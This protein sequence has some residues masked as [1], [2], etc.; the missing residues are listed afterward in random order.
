MDATTGSVL[1]ALGVALITSI[2]AV[3]VAFVNNRKE[4][5]GSADA[6]M[7]AI[8]RQRIEFGEDRLEAAGLELARRNEII[9]ELRQALARCSCRT[10]EVT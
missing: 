3:V 7:E 5:T 2:T 4:R 1:G 9:D 10:E 8:L 6:G